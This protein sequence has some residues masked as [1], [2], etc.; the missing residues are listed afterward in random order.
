MS[1][2]QFSRRVDELL[3]TGR[4]SLSQAIAQAATED[5]QYVD[6]FTRARR[7]AL[8]TGKML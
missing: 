5:S 4:Y 6:S 1:D 8:D 7:A 3:A 2:S